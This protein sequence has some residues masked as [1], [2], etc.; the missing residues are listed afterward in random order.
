M[1]EPDK[2]STDPAVVQT[3]D[4]DP[5]PPAEVTVEREAEAAAPAEV[6]VEKEVEEAPPPVEVIDQTKRTEGND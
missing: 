1:G 2:N 3:V 6:T 4:T 5:A